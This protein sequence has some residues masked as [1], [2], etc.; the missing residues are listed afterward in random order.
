VLYLRSL[1]NAFFEQDRPFYGLQAIPSPETSKPIMDIHEIARLNILAIQ[2]IQASGS[3]VLCGHSFGSWVALEMAFQ[4]QAAGHEV[5]QL[6]ILDTGIPSEKD[7]TRIQNWD[8]GEWLM[9]VAK[10]IGDTYDKKIDLNLEELSQVNWEGQIQL[11]F[12]QMNIHGLIDEHSGIE[13]VRSL[14]EMYKAQAQTIYTPKAAKV[15]HLTLIRAETVLA[16]FLEGMPLELQNNPFW[17]W[18][19]FSQSKPVLE[20]VPGNH[21][22]MVQ[23]PNAHILA[24]ILG[25]ILHQNDD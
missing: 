8:D 2:Q 13:Q 7:L 20:F 25:I 11:L 12:S 19:Q 21:L 6:I 18:E 15:P 17:G 22:T 16:D 24:N 5:S 4:L 3:Y 1:A 14:V 10:I 23:P 9:M